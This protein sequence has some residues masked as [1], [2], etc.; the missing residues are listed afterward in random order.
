[1]LFVTLLTLSLIIT[2][3]PLS[4]AAN[5]TL[6]LNSS[7]ITGVNVWYHSEITPLQGPF[8]TNYATT[9]QTSDEPIPAPGLAHGA[10]TI[11]YELYPTILGVDYILKALIINGVEIISYKQQ[12]VHCE[13]GEVDTGYL[14][15]AI[16]ADTTIEGVYEELTRGPKIDKLRF[17]VIRSP[18]AQLI[19]MQT[20]E[21]DV[22][23]DL[24]RTGDIEKLDGEGFTITAAPGFH[25]GFIGY[26]IRPDQTYKL[27]GWGS[28]IAGPILSNMWFRK[29]LFQ[30]YNQ[31]E[32]VASIYK[33]IVTPVQSLVPPAMGGW[34]NPAVP[35]Q[36]YNP[37][38]PDL[39]TNYGGTCGVPTSYPNRYPNDVSACG[40]LRR[41]GFINVGTN[42]VTPYDLDDDG[43]PGTMA[44]TDCDGTPDAPG[45]EAECT[46]DNYV[47]DPDDVIPILLVFTPLYE[48][49][50]TS[51]E[52]GARFVADCNAIDVPLSHEPREFD[53]Y[54]DKVFGVGDT[55]GGHF[56]LFM[57]FYSL[58]R[59]PDHLYDM[60][61]SSFDSRIQPEGRNA[62]GIHS[63][64]LDEACETIKYSL[65]HDAKIAAAYAA[66]EMLYLQEYPEA[67][68]SYMLLYSRILFNG[69]K[70]GLKAS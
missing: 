46:Y 12:V 70:P 68:F 65:D 6:T 60:C 48:V 64:E 44:D 45:T 25:M 56:D 31:E 8:T 14:R 50:P 32:I 39:D 1:M 33:Y 40:K 26:N 51:A 54:L 34:V 15:V 42:W 24:I 58:G 20:C 28:K 29:A 37:G 21:V 49:A 35:K 23:T 36:P 57:V 38:D 52:H 16:F 66:Q 43:T 3:V 17:K 13:L 4:Y 69:F 67:A 19:A 62:P 22:L 9:V 41:A 2:Y 5:V 55:P 30:C 27:D 7:P 59:F 11:K 63:D 53:P 47:A 10:Y 18:D 61:H